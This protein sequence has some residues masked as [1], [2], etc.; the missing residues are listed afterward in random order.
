MVSS[1]TVTFYDLY[2]AL[3]LNWLSRE[4]PTCPTCKLVFVVAYIFQHFSLKLTSIKA[5]KSDVFKASVILLVLTPCKGKLFS[6]LKYFVNFSDL[7][8]H[9]RSKW[10]TNSGYFCSGVWE[11]VLVKLLIFSF[12]LSINHK[13][14]FWTIVTILVNNRF[15]NS[16]VAVVAKTTD[17]IQCMPLTQNVKGWWSYIFQGIDCASCNHQWWK[18]W[19]QQAAPLL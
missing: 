6:I 4:F 15:L 1:G 3:H 8:K 9:C 14:S 19:S 7:V 17:S 13:P 11:K 18:L 12:G 10:Q 16:I 2:L 5:D